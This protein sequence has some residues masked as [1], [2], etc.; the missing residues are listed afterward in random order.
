MFGIASIKT[1]SCSQNCSLQKLHKQGYCSLC[2]TI[3]ADYSHKARLFLNYDVAFL[4][5]LTSY[6][7]TKEETV[8]K[9]TIIDCFRI[10]K[11][12]T[13]SE[14][15]HFFASINVYLAH[16]TVA[17]KITDK[18]GFKWKCLDEF[19]QKDF[20]QASA[21]LTKIGFP[22]EQCDLLLASQSERENSSRTTDL[23]YYA[24]TT[25]QVC[26]MVYSFAAS[27]AGIKDK[28]QFRKIGYN[29]GTIVY[30]ADAYN[31][32][33]KDIKKG[34][35]NPIA[36]QEG[37]TEEKLEKA[38]IQIASIQKELNSNIE[39]TS[40]STHYKDYLCSVINTNLSEKVSNKDIQK[41]TYQ[42]SLKS[43]KIGQKVSEI[44][45]KSK[46]VL[47]GF[48]NKSLGFTTKLYG[49]KSFLAFT[50]FIFI[51]S[52]LA[53]E[54]GA[55]MDS[56][57][58]VNDC[59]RC[60]D[61]CEQCC[62]GCED[63]CSNC[64]N[65]CD[66]CNNC[67]KDFEDCNDSCNKCCDSPGNNSGDCN[68]CRWC[69]CGS[70]AVILLIIAAIVGFVILIV[71]LASGNSNKKPPTYKQPENKQTP[72]QS[73]NQDNY[74]NTFNAYT[75]EK[76]NSETGYVGY[77]EIKKIPEIEY[78]TT[79]VKNIGMVSASLLF[80]LFAFSFLTE[81]NDVS[82]YIITVTCTMAIV[83]LLGAIF[84]CSNL[85]FRF[86]YLYSWAIL[87]MI[88]YG[89]G[90]LYVLAKYLLAT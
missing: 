16:K 55:D 34:Q 38:L 4:Q 45:A 17:D 82:I 32:F 85:P 62:N 41:H 59:D 25:A 77:D 35:F 52:R 60:C 39:A 78:D 61:G 5:E 66:E 8:S 24:E 89:V 33:H 67:C 47:S 3:A 57:F 43:L 40:I 63:C 68:C 22:L 1:S 80:F 6:Y 12:E 20:Q 69:C 49:L 65:C 86:R 54:S 72:P 9:H 79:K 31:D 37:K 26:S 29:F 13:L 44:R 15:Q 90:L 21:Y 71:K 27:L 83:A 50:L 36:L 88:F 7:S 11:A 73:E 19:Y 53:A 14:T 70:I 81:N 51:S 87:T 18:E 2:K 76:K 48:D 23:Y 28:E 58:N 56:A 30:L 46:I 74:S 75:A 10:P 64:Q 42:N 84:P